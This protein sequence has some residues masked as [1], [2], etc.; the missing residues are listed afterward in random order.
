[1]H[2]MGI[3]MEVI[4]IVKASIP[5]DAADA[6][7]ACINLKIGKLSAVVPESLRFCFQV[8]TEGTVL[9]GAKLVI[10][11]IPVKA[12]CSHCLH[13]WVVEQPVF[14]CPSCNGRG[15]ELLSG[16]ELDILSIELLEADGDLADDPK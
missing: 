3:V 13:Q 14:I 16:R 4:D 15:I 11:E 10:D 5:A 2:E 7:V 12:R 9:A 8:A 1:M 6:Q